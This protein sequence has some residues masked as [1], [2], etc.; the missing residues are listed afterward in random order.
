MLPKLNLATA[1]GTFGYVFVL[2]FFGYIPRVDVNHALIPP[3]EPNYARFTEWVLSFGVVPFGSAV[4]AYFLSSSFEMHNILSKLLGLRYFWDRFYIVRPLRERAQSD[5]PLN[6]ALVRRVMTE[7]YYKQIKS[8]DSHFVELFWRYAMQFWMIFE[9]AV[10]VAASIFILW[11]MHARSVQGP[12]WYL[13]AVVAIG[14][15][16]FFLVTVRK[17]ADEI[18]QISTQSIVEYFEGLSPIARL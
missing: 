14:I 16:Q 5:V 13:V 11:I 10:V 12:A 1:V 18:R 9:H 4:L 3:L 15:A 8:L 7:F 17:T 6:R 2:A